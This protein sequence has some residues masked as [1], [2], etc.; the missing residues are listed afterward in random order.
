MQT[1]KIGSRQETKLESKG[2][3]YFP[4]HRYKFYRNFMV[5]KVQTFQSSL[6]STYVGWNHL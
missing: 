6:I 5:P 3:R 4:L 1:F 2:E